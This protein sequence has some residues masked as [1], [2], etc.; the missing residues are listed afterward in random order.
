M[1]VRT[2]EGLGRFSSCPADLDSAATDLAKLDRI[3]KAIECELKLAFATSTD[4]RLFERRQ[5]LK[6]L[7][8]SVPASL[9]ST[10]QRELEEAQTTFAKLFW[11]RLH[12]AT[13]RELLSVL[14][15]AFF[16]E[17]ELGFDPQAD[18]FS[19]D[20]NPALTA[21][22]KTQRKQ[23]VN[24]LIGDAISSPGILWRRQ[25][26]RV[27]AALDGAGAVPS[28][29]PL[30]GVALGKAVKRLSDAQ[31][32]LF[33]GSF[34]DGTGGIDFTS[35]QSCFERFANGEL[36]DPS[37]SGHVG[38]GEPNGGNYFLFA[39]FAFL[40]IELKLD[41]AV[42]TKALRTFV[43]T[44]EIFMHI[45]REKAVSPPPAVNIPSPTSGAER[46]DILPVATASDPGFD[47]SFFSAIGGS[48]TVGKGQ[49][50]FRRKMALRAKYDAMDVSALKAA[51][52]DNLSRA[53]RMP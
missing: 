1:Y 17:Y 2:L 10:L 34:P 8:R 43:K 51:A 53:V 32:K 39:E 52:R 15:Q 4:L 37:L 7:F 21:A 26:A 23:D 30:P 35:F 28:S 12:P 22:D 20:T 19:I 18:T 41:E 42:W 33:R 16:K 45:Y 36:R 24:D 11:G 40:C 3:R 46:R 47:F 13:S 25:L 49:S 9:A 31:V 44:Q 48:V 29:L 50:D 27:D 14:C 5:R 6:G 38:F